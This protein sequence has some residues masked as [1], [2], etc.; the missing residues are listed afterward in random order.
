MLIWARAWIRKGL[1]IIIRDQI[2]SSCLI[3]GIVPLFIIEGLSVVLRAK[4]RHVI[5]LILKNGCR[6]RIRDL[7][8]AD[9]INVVTRAS[10]YAALL[11][12]TYHHGGAGLLNIDSAQLVFQVL[13]L[14]LQ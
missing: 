1:R 5:F 8:V 11:H 12:S 13:N 6:M 14:A 10:K 4:R 9:N 3:V 7:N 2:T